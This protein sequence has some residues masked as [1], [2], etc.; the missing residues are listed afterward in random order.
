MRG[1]LQRG[2]EGVDWVHVDGVVVLGDELLESGQL[3]LDLDLGHNWVYGQD[4]RVDTM[5]RCAVIHLFYGDVVCITMSLTHRAVE[6]R[7]HRQNFQSCGVIW[8]IGDITYLCVVCVLRVRRLCV[9]G[10]P[11]R[12]FC[13]VY[14]PLS[15]WAV[16]MGIVILQ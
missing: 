13:C 7:R 5:P 10:W 3:W 14:Y 6:I 4:E 16:L 1:Q 15:G 11:R 9:I 2:Q 8:G 12:V